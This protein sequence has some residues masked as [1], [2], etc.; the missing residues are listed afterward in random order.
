MQASTFTPGPWD[1]HIV[2]SDAFSVP[3]TERHSRFSKIIGER[4]LTKAV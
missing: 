1:G 4:T 2:N 3:I